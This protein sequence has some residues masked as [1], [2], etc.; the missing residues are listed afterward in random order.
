MSQLPEPRRSPRLL[1]NGDRP[2]AA[3]QV[4][5][6]GAVALAVAALLNAETLRSTFDRMPQGSTVRSV[7]LRLTDPIYEVSRALRFDRPGE[8]VDALRGSDQG[9]DGSFDALTTT[10]AAST[11]P[12]DPALP[13]DPAATTTAAPV[14]GTTPPVVVANRPPG[15]PTPDNPAV[16]YIAGDSDAGTI[17]PSL[18]RL[19]GETGVVDS[20]LDYKVSSGLTR[21]DFFDWPRRMQA[22]MAEVGP[23][24]VV[25]TFGGNDAQP[26][27]VDGKGYD[28]SAPEWSAEYARR[29]G[30]MMDYLSSEGR[31]LIWVGIPNAQSA[32]LTS[33]LT[34]QREAV[35]A[36]AAKR[37]QVVLVDSWPMFSGVNGGYADYVDI[38]GDFKL[39][40]A[41]DGFHLNQAGADL[42]AERHQ[43][44]GRRGVEGAGRRAL[45]WR[46]SSQPSE[47]SGGRNG[48]RTSPSRTSI[49]AIQP[50]S[51]EKCS[52]RSLLAPSASVSSAS[53]YRPS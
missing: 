32:E 16:L 2:L 24:I 41:D 46:A 38:N 1:P 26:I 9:G 15:P 51:A 22:K 37:P 4:I 48:T 45:T 36:E 35:L 14:A 43:R 27:K 13:V 29:V 8:R 6:V 20:V 44:E 34:F 7:G 17:G 5:A 52:S 10:T 31:T 42:L 11:V 19:A 28:V 33:R 21:P 47:S 3:A 18:Q 53:S 12:A 30:A 23:Q 49:D 50:P 40:R 25:V 39:V